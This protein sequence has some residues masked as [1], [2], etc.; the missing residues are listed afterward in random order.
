MK[1]WTVWRHN[2][3]NQLF[4]KQRFG[5]FEVDFNLCVWNKR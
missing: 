2:Q 1:S 4:K 5:H 3:A